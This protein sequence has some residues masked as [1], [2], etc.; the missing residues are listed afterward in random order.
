MEFL[1]RL[2]VAL[3]C[4]ALGA[5][6]LA[7]VPAPPAKEFG[8]PPGYRFCDSAKEFRQA[9]KLLRADKDLSLNDYQIIAFSRKIAKGCDGAAKRVGRVY[10][11]LK[12][13]G[14]AQGHS[15]ETALTF[16]GL[17]DS[18]VEGFLEI[19]KKVFL[20]NYLNLDFA[21]AYKVSLDMSRDY[22]GD[23][24][25]LKNDFVSLVDFCLSEKGLAMNYALCAEFTR[26]M[27]KFTDL[28]PEGVFPEFKRVYDYLR[29]DKKTGLGI[30]ESV[31]VIPRILSKGAKAPENFISMMNYLTE[32]DSV[33][34]SNKEVMKLAL[35]VA[36][37]SMTADPNYKSLSESNP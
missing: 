25:K 6:V 21:N 18:R 23:P 28:F 36:D 15:F 19:F 32:K 4:I 10:Y 5:P 30:K 31:E 34:S 9:F 8:P 1:K 35:M 11:M 17:N 33:V 14:M 20:E 16:A 3:I 2:P 13:S 12:Q 22:K 26:R 27:V 37:L 24:Q 7:A 29:F